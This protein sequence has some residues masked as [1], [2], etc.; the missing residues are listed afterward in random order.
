MGFVWLRYADAMESIR[1]EILMRIPTL[2]I[3]ATIS[4]L[5]A[6]PTQAQTYGGNAPICLQRWYWGGGETFYCG[7]SS[8]AQCHANAS[9][10]S[11]MCVTN[12]YFA[13]AQVPREPAYRQPRRAY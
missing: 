8:M 12:P 9:G 4:V 3:W 11:A 7:Y 1:K 2:A 5:A 13:N 10:L 6:A